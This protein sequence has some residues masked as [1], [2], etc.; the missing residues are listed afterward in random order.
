MTI[1]L[2]PAL[3]RIVRDKVNAGLYANETDLVCEALRHEFA[4]DALHE[5]V[6]TQAAGGFAQLEAGDFEDLTRDELMSRLA[7]RRASGPCA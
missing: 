2:P 5:W 3:E 1:T 6:R 4:G 7:Q